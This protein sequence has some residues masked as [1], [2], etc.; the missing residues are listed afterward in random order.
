MIWLQQGCKQL[1]HTLHATTLHNVNLPLGT[2]PCGGN[3]TSFIPWKVGM[4][5]F[6]FYDVGILRPVV[7]FLTLKIFLVISHFAHTTFIVVTAKQSL[8]LP[9]GF[10]PQGVMYFLLERVLSAHPY[11]YTQNK[12]FVCFFQ[13]KTWIIHY[14]T[15]CLRL[16]SQNHYS[17]WVPSG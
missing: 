4:W 9:M 8:Y 1:C 2:P 14:S 17:P 10:W 6:Q 5:L 11:N 16:K 3:F 15:H 7:N 12:C 13:T